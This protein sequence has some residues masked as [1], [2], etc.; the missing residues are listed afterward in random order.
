MPNEERFYEADSSPF[1]F[2][3]AYERPVPTLMNVVIVPWMSQFPYTSFSITDPF[4]FL[5]LLQDTFLR[6]ALFYLQA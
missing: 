2:C 6:S 3:T 4:D 5:K 1:V